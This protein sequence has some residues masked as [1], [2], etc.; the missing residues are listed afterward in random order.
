MNAPHLHPSSFFPFLSSYLLHLVPSCTPSL[1]PPSSPSSLWQAVQQVVTNL[2]I[3][4]IELRSE[5][6]FDIQ[7]YTHRR[8]VEKIV[9]PLEGEIER[10]RVEFLK[11]SAC[12]CIVFLGGSNDQVALWCLSHTHMYT[13]H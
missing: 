9:V 3:S 13:A 11:V 4:Q 6:S 1:L 12:R 5:D 2:L 10:L 7:Q 8:K